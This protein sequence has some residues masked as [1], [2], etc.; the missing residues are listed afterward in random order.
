MTEEEIAKWKED[1]R[2]AGE[3]TKEEW[4]LCAIVLF[5]FLI[6]ALIKGG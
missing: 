3:T 1:K 6:G 2:R 4:R 5:I